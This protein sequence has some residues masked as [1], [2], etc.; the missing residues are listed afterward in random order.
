MKGENT[1][2]QPARNSVKKD[3]D[4]LRR[5]SVLLSGK[6]SVAEITCAE[7]GACVILLRFRSNIRVNIS[8]R[9]RINREMRALIYC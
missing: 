4:M 8:C 1:Y 2:F 9:R 6:G 7:R 3:A 5:R